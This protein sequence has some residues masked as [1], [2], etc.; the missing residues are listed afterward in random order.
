MK[1]G[2]K[3]NYVSNSKPANQTTMYNMSGWIW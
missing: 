1:N 2:F 3:F